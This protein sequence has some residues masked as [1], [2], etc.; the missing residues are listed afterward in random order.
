MN[1]NLLCYKKILLYAAE[2]FSPHKQLNV[3][4]KEYS[5]E[6]ISYAIKKLGEMGLVETQDLTDSGGI[7]F[8]INDITANGWKVIDKLKRISDEELF[9]NYSDLLELVYEK[10]IINSGNLKSKQP[11]SNMMRNTIIAGLLVA[12]V[13]IF[14]LTP[15]KDFLFYSPS[16]NKTNTES[17]SKGIDSLK[18]NQTKIIQKHS[19]AVDS[20]IVIDKLSSY[21]N[22]SNLKLVSIGFLETSQETKNTVLDIKVRNVGNKVAF[23]TKAIFTI[24]KIWQLKPFSE[25]LGYKSVSYNYDIKLSLN[26]YPYSIEK[27]IS[28]EIKSN[29]VDRFTFTLGNDS[30]S[31][32]LL[33]R[34]LV[35]FMKIVLIYNEDNHTIGTDNLLFSPGSEFVDS[36]YFNNKYSLPDDLPPSTEYAKEILVNN[37]KIFSDLLSIK[38]VKNNRIKKLINYYKKYYSNN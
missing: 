25:P 29:D 5:A 23:I 38:A 13:T 10:E 12:V 21:Q 36:S 31:N 6:E 18:N 17:I 34:D 26:N 9:D 20:N 28:Q 1:K 27:N 22:D 3:D 8:R 11:K 2:N 4:I 14:I 7:D 35:F 19:I 24:E 15:L 30:L 37:Q 16:P 32:Q 33:W